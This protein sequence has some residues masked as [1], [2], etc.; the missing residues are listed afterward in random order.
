MIRVE[1]RPELLRWARGRA[2]LSTADLAKRFPKLDD[3][4]TGRA[5]P[6]LKQLERFAKATVT[7]VGFMFLEAPP[8]EEVPIPDFR[9]VENV[10]TERPSPDLLDTI[11]VCQQRQEWYRDFAR[12]MGEE[13]LSIVGSAQPTDGVEATAAR[14]RRALDFDVEERRRI[15]TWTEALRRLSGKRMPPES[16]SC[17]AEWC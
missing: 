16:W 4:E 14:M 9:T 13:P 10:H 11:Y 17:A 2:G 5:L 12:S 8:V 7:P 3:R 1:V 15:P 6:T